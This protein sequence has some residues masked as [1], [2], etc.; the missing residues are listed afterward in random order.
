MA[1]RGGVADALSSVGGAWSVTPLVYV[2]YSPGDEQWRTRLDK[3]LL[4]LAQNRQI[5]IWHSHRKLADRP[6]NAQEAISSAALVVVLLSDNY[7][8][9]M[10]RDS[11]LLAKLAS[12]NKVRIVSI[13]VRDCDWKRLDWVTRFEIH[14]ADVPLEKH[15]HKE[16]DKI[17]S[18]FANHIVELASAGRRPVAG[19]G[20]TVDPG[21]SARKMAGPPSGPPKGTVDPGASARNIA[22]APTGTG[23]GPPPITPGPPSATPRPE[24]APPGNQPSAATRKGGILKEGSSG[25]DVQALQQ[26]LKDLGFDP[27]GVD[28][29][30]GSGTKAAIVAFQESRGFVAD[31]I[32]GP[33]VWHALDSEQQDTP[34]RPP[35]GT[36]GSGA[37]PP[38]ITPGPPS[39]TVGP[40]RG[41]D[42]V[43]KFGLSTEARELLRRAQVLATFGKDSANTP[44]VTTSCLLFAIAETGRDQSGTFPTEQFLWRQLQ[45]ADAAAYRRIFRDRFPRAQYRGTDE[46]I[47][48][49]PTESPSQS[50]TPNVFK[51]FEQAQVL[52]SPSSPPSPVE[53]VHIL[54]SLL[55]TEEAKAFERLSRIMDVTQ[56]R[57]EFL[58]F[59]E[60]S[61]PHEDLEAWQKSLGGEASALVDEAPEP[62]EI[63]DDFTSPL[64]GFAADFWKGEDL[65]DITRDVNALAS[66]AAATSID[67]PLSIGLFG[68]WGSG[69]SHFMRQMRARVE[70]LS[71]KARESGKLQSELGYHKRI[72]Q[73]EFNAWHY[74]EGNLWASLV[75]HIFNNLKLTEQRD[76]KSHVVEDA[77]LAIMEKLELNQ[78]L[79]KKIEARQQALQGKAKAA[80]QEFEKANVKRDDKWQDLTKLRQSKE[81]AV[82]EL[83]SVTLSTE[84]AEL[85]KQIG[86]PDGALH[87]P[88]EIQKKYHEAKT[89]WGSIRGQWTVFRSD[90]KRLNKLIRVLL[91]IAVTVLVGWFFRNVLKTAYAYVA[92]VVT[93]LIG[94]WAAAK[95]YIKK[96][97]ESMGALKKKYEDVEQERQ[98][99]IIALESEVTSLT[100][101]MAT[102]ETEA[103]AI[104]A[105]VAKLEIELTTTN[106]AKLLANFIED[107]AACSDYRRHLGV[108]ALIRRDFEKLSEL[109]GEQITSEASS[110]DDKQTV[111][112]IILYIDDLDRCPPKNV[113][114]VLQAIHLLLAFPL[115]V[116]IVGVDARWVTR[117]LQ[118]S[119]EWLAADEDGEGPEQKKQDE[120]DDKVVVTPHDYLEKIFQIPFWLKPM[121]DTDCRN[122]LVGLTKSSRVANQENGGGGQ[123]ENESPAPNPPDSSSF[124]NQADDPQSSASPMPGQPPPAEAPSQG[125]STDSE[126]QSV[127]AIDS[128]P[129]NLNQSATAN[130]SAVESKAEEKI[131]LD[132]KSLTLTDVEI[133]YMTQ[134]SPLI[135]RSPRAVKRFLNCYRLIKVNLKPNHL[136]AFIGSKEEPGQ[137]TAVMVL[138][139]MI[140]GA[141]T[142]SLPLIEEL[143]KYSSPIKRVDLNT[144]L[145]QL[146]KNPDLVKHPDWALV[147]DFLEEHILS[148]TEPTFESLIDM[149]PQVSRYSFKVAKS[150]STRRRPLVT[151]RPKTS[152]PAAV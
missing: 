81:A 109:L 3:F 119:Y 126:A 61:F 91:V 112:R 149:T 101:E 5:S 25:P 74:I 49:E 90:S 70:K 143:E 31:G 114:Q 68:D 147:R 113:V 1:K 92:S 7:L 86:L 76:G 52:T 108:L 79:K 46:T 21:A 111:S 69:K 73:I 99:K 33:K 139:G 98:K 152:A 104:S 84:Q 15:S 9:S 12:A 58:K 41:V 11:L 53:A 66:L 87:V 83:P 27:V 16:I 60:R 39:A 6:A 57:A 134:L 145:Q 118:E 106:A 93:F 13:L 45:R 94:A 75:E 121:G 85:L 130:Q 4:P 42:V 138:L 107:R 32:V 63:D 24:A 102:A 133:E 110:A 55:I 40:R 17:L 62:R 115:F 51:V 29:N 140:T 47:N 71:Q 8:S 72:V 35:T 141:P 54:G 44:Q 82:N 23:S 36:V 103:K 38:P 88:A 67:P 78:E 128:E 77:Q 80:K 18:D 120:S 28:G 116:V 19:S 10:S 136:D 95:P 34:P 150:R 135:K 123:P 146:E 43:S 48:F 2:S 127:P 105:E 122:L 148:T 129:A 137:F 100:N 59:V 89:F 125:T 124:T 20:A 22:D 14:S 37:G 142:I 117:S 131:D 97:N 151:K 26:R 144:F 50:I 30:F 56:L 65:L 96:F 64:A 132:P